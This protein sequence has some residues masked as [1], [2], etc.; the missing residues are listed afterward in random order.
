MRIH[1]DAKSYGE[2]A[3]LR[4]IDL[5]LDAGDRIAVLGPSGIGK[6]TLL[7]I[8]AGL[9]ESFDGEVDNRPKRLGMVF[10]EPFLMNW[11]NAQDN[12]TLMTGCSAQKAQELLAQMG[13]EGLAK[14]LPQELSIGQQRR[15][16]LARAFAA[17]PE[18]LILDEAF[19]SLDA[20][21]A[22]LMRKNVQDYAKAH[23][24]SLILATHQKA[25][26]S[27]AKQCFLLKDGQ[28]VAQ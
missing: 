6:S 12:L 1:I 14:R 28:L 2:N 9:D 19:T 17:E 3:I 22:E 13:L 5:D 4:G 21:T 8:I 18:L 24:V 10:Q 23:P 20:K 7:R 11:K 16:S 27:L 15:V 26:L 25:D